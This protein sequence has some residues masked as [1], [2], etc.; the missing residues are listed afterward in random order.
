MKFLFFTLLIFTFCLALTKREV[1]KR[2]PQNQSE[3]TLTLYYNVISCTC[4]Q[5][6]EDT[7]KENKDYY[8]L[9]PSNDNLMKADTLFDGE[10]LPVVVEVT[11]RVVLTKGY[12]KG[13]KPTK[14]ADPGN[15]F[16]Y[17]KIRV[18]QNGE[19]KGGGD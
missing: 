16:R 17:T 11:G 19:K 18:L 12:P 15:V 8:Y 1:D 6:S 14:G 5:W 13:F 9:E 7:E 3:K 10:H 2:I 4:A